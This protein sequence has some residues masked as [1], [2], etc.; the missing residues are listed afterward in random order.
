[1]VPCVALGERSRVSH[2]DGAIILDRS[3]LRQEGDVWISK[4]KIRCG[5][6]MAP[7]G[8]RLNNEN[9][10]NKLVPAVLC[11]EVN[12]MGILRVQEAPST[13]CAREGVFNIL[14]GLGMELAI[15]ISGGEDDC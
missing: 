11:C 5:S 10:S 3:G 12:R 1:M 8:A 2:M 15:T 9:I 4:M 14:E 7:K 13:P 6:Q